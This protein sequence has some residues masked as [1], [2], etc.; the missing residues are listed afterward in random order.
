MQKDV[1]DCKRF[2]KAKTAEGL[3]V[4]MF[5]NNL[6]TDAYHDYQIVHDGKDWYAWFEYDAS[7]EQENIAK[8]ALNQ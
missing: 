5:E 2:L 4:L 8:K 6:K 1:K 7:A 3:R